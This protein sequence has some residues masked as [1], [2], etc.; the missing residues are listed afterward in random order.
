M[1]AKYPHD[2]TFAFNSGEF[3]H[4]ENLRE[5]ARRIA[6]KYGVMP[7]RAWTLRERMD[8]IESGETVAFGNP[9]RRLPYGQH[10]GRTYEQVACFDP[11]Y[12]Q[13]MIMSGRLKGEHADYARNALRCRVALH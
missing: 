3:D 12:L 4:D 6:M 2:F 5:Q 13:Y 8:M 11:N 1:A 7:T 10:K 9:D